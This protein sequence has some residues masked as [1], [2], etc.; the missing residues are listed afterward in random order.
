[1]VGKKLDSVLLEAINSGDI[2]QIEEA[3]DAGADPNMILENGNPLF[4]EIAFNGDLELLELFIQKGADVKIKNKMGQSALDGA[5]INQN[6]E[7]AQLLI[8]H[9][10]DVDAINEDGLGILC[11]AVV[12]GDVDFIELLLEKGADPNKVYT[13]KISDEMRK[14]L[15]VMIKN[16]AFNKKEMKVY[17]DEKTAR[18]IVAKNLK[19][20]KTTALKMAQCAKEGEIV[21]L[22]KKYGA[23]Q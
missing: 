6:M 7:I 8:E 18:E 2:N 21:E 13:Q 10:A 15:G 20:T 3:F 4:I 5:I 19:E 23:T 22:L 11:V 17:I 12:S 14:I 9:G 1:M 16:D